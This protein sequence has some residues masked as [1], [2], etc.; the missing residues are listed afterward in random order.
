MAFASHDTEP[1]HA[2]LHGETL[3]KTPMALC[4]LGAFALAHVPTW[5]VAEQMT[6]RVL[7]YSRATFKT[8]APL[9]TVIGNASGPG[10][11]GTVTGDPARL[12]D[13][14][15]TIRV[16]LSTLHTGIDRRDAQMQSK[17]FLDTENEVDRYATFE[18]KGIEPDAGLEPDKEVPAKI[19]GTLTIRH[20]PIDITSDARIT[21]VQLT[22]EQLETQK[23]FG[24]TSD[25]FRVRA[26]F[27]TSFTNHGMQVPQLLILKLA[28]V[29]QIE[30]DLTLARQLPAPAGRQGRSG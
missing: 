2:F 17:E 24:F 8:E 7:P 29:I 25:N 18:L 4:L 3:M 26:Q 22:P 14:S 9:E 19:R 1:H 6:L 10:V 16:D 11:T 27:T 23:R 12:Q 20:Q 15:G 5:A 13:A 21:Y 30:I 28:N